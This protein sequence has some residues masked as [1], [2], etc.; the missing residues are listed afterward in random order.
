VD[1]SASGLTAR[2]PFIC[3]GRTRRESRDK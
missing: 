3:R 2:A 1:G